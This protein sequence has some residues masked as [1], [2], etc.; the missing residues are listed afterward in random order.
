MRVLR[1]VGLAENVA[2][3]KALAVVEDMGID[4]LSDCGTCGA[5]SSTAEQCAHQSPG[6]TTN[7][8]A[9]RTGNHAECCTCFCTTERSSGATGS[10]RDSTDRASG[11]AGIVTCG[12]TR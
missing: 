7:D 5:A 3:L 1:R 9:D 8:R 12:N 4:L 6:H 2:A 11:F 10:A